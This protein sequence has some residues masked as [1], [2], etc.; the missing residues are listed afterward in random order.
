MVNWIGSTLM[1]NPLL[2]G[3]DGAAALSDGGPQDDFSGVDLLSRRGG[4]GGPVGR[5][6][7]G[8]RPARPRPAAAVSRAAYRWIRD[9]A[10]GLGRTPGGCDIGDL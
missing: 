1:G 7:L 9:A 5:R 6:R 8:R 3:R 4:K 2:A 10:S